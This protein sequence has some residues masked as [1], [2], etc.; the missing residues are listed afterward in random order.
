MDVNVCMYQPFCE[1]EILSSCFWYMNFG[2][3]R[4]QG[5]IYCGAHRCFRSWDVRRSARFISK[6]NLAINV[7]C[8]AENIL[9]QPKFHIVGINNTSGYCV[10][11]IAVYARHLW[12]SAMYFLFARLMNVCLKIQWDGHQPNAKYL[13]Q[14]VFESFISA[15]GLAMALTKRLAQGNPIP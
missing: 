8:V 3:L 13:Y 7:F 6:Q 9:E 10:Q 11:A 12:C 1:T 4:K 15:K 2:L 5:E 14:S